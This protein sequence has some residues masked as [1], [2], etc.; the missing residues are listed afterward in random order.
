MRAYETSV[1]KHYVLNALVE[2]TPAIETELKHLVQNYHQREQRKETIWQI[3][4]LFAAILV[5]LVI[6][7]VMMCWLTKKNPLKN[8]QP[9][10]D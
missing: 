2:F 8:N 9:E 7:Y 10:D 5:G 1:G 6:V 4:L 3:E